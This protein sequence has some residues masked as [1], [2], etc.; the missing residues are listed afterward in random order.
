MEYIRHPTP[1]GCIFCN[2]PTLSDDASLIV[3]R[4]EHAFVMLNAFPYNNGHLLVAPYKHTAE[5]C[6]LSCEERIMIFDLVERG[7]SLLREIA[8]PDGFNIGVNLGQ[9]AGAGIADHLHFHVVPRWNGDTNF[10]PVISDA[11]VL[12]EALEKVWA[13]LHTAARQRK[14]GNGR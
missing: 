2:K 3:E 13:K 5:M 7:I 9:T 11:K 1:V 6:E 14:T 10:M 8:Q 12:P 4:G